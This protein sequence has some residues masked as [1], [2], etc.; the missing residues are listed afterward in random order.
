MII[1][2]VPSQAAVKEFSQSNLKE[3]CYAKLLRIYEILVL[4]WLHERAV[5]FVILIF[6]FMCNVHVY[7][8]VELRVMV[9]ERNSTSTNIKVIK[10]II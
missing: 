10:V 9:N 3:K 5:L 8:D 2:P 6:L 4:N 7:R 1:Y